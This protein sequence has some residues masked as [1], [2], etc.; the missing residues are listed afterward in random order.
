MAPPKIPS[1]DYLRVYPGLNDFSDVLEAIPQAI[2]GHLTNLKEVKAKCGSIGLKVGNEIK[3]YFQNRNPESLRQISVILDTLLPAIGQKMHIAALAAEQVS[4]QFDRLDIDYRMI[5]EHEVPESVQV[6]HNDPAFIEIVPQE[7]QASI[8]SQ[9][10]RE[11]R[12]AREAKRAIQQQESR[13][14]TT[15]NTLEVPLT[16]AA[17]RRGRGRNATPQILVNALPA[18]PLRDAQVHLNHTDRLAEDE[19]VL[20]TPV[21]QDKMESFAEE[22]VKPDPRARHADE[23]EPKLRASQLPPVV[24]P[25]LEKE[26][27]SD[28]PPGVTKNTPKSAE[29]GGADVIIGMKR[30]RGSAP[31][32]SEPVYCYCQRGS[33]GE[34]V[35]CD[36]PHCEREWFHLG[37]IGLS[38]LPKGQWFCEECRAKLRRR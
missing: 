30:K 18:E 27:N 7:R 5:R 20:S 9:A 17:G 21:Q 33:F 32:S 12:E 26:L 10:R 23:R 13:S 4:H 35:G 25:L 38:A 2:G 28:E 15:S 6:Q 22:D 3:S 31:K 37:C 34:M 19:D 14:A 16:A 11:A 8:R 24:M 36:G 29:E 1:V